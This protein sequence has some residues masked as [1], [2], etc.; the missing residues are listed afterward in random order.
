MLLLMHT[1]T[2]NSKRLPIQDL[3]SA[4]RHAKLLSGELRTASKAVKEHGILEL[5]RWERW[6][7]KF[8]DWRERLLDED[9]PFYQ[10]LFLEYDGIELARSQR[11]DYWT[12]DRLP[13]DWYGSEWHAA[14]CRESGSI[15]MRPAH[16]ELVD[17]VI[18]LDPTSVMVVD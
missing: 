12:P 8:V 7:T 3:S 14:A 16:Q 6:V 10:E 17:N 4:F 15:A 18:S 2:Q 13:D 5:L 11:S 1:L 9:F